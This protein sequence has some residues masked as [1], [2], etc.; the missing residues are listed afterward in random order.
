MFNYTYYLDNIQRWFDETREYLG[1]QVD[2]VRLDISLKLISL[3][4]ALIVGGLCVVMGIIAL[5][6]FS[7]ALVH[8][9]AAWSGSFSLS[10]VGI[11]LL[12]VLAI[13]MILIFRKRLVVNPVT[14]LVSN[15]FLK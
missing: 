7:F 6:Y 9:L 2:Y 10:Y 1:L 14:R 11:A 8:W 3:L 4:S 15:L 13:G 5:F 12:W